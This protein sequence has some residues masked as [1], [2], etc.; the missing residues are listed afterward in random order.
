MSDNV[1][2]KAFSKATATTKVVSTGTDTDKE[3]V[4][5]SRNRI[6]LHIYANTQT[7]T[8]SPDPI[9]NVAI[10]ILVA[11]GNPLH[12]TQWEYGDLATLEWHG[13]SVESDN[14]TIVEVIATC[15][16]ATGH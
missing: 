14:V 9:S 11:P 4:S 13:R 2:E 8:V 1:L 5:R 16:C 3:L 6:A 12:I 7:V 10:G 15:P